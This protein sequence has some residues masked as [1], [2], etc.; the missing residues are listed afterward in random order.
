LI[1]GTVAILNFHTSKLLFGCAIETDPAL[2][3][4][5]FVCGRA[6]PV[7]DKCDKSAEI[8][9]KVRFRAKAT[10]VTVV[11][12]GNDKRLKLVFS[13]LFSRIRLVTAFY[14]PSMIVATVTNPAVFVATV[15]SISLTLIRSSLFSELQVAPGP[16]Q[17]N[18]EID[19]IRSF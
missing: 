16:P 10:V 19:R 1:D 3:T 15:F 7:L 13:G 8:Q 9:F 14:R 17:S 2:L 11:S 5:V 6:V 18:H 12:C 4:L